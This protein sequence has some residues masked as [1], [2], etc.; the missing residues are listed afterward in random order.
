MQP[1]RSL[2]RPSGRHGDGVIAEDGL[3][4]VVPLPQPDTPAAAEVNGGK[5]LH[6]DVLLRRVS[7]RSVQH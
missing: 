3:L 2:A 7:Q 5:D 6:G 4:S 1:G